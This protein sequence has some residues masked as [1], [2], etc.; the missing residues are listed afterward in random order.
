MMAW[1]WILLSALLSITGNSFTPLPYRLA[2]APNNRRL[3][4]FVNCLRFNDA[5]IISN[6]CE[7][8]YCLSVSVRP[9]GLFQFMFLIY[10]II[11]DLKF[12]LL[13]EGSII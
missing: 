7:S 8:K 2:D 3:S 4:R 6:F 13:F 5:V 12:E 9:N 10:S 1:M 11:E